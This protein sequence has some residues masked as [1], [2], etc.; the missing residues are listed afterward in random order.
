MARI[1]YGVQ[2]EGRGHSSR[3]KIII[4]HL[5]Q[6]G[7]QVK[8]FTSYK[9]YEYLCQFFDDVTN[10]LGLGFVFDGAQL[11]I[12]RTMQ[13]NIQDGASD[14][15]K[16]IMVLYKTFK[17]FRPD[18]AITDFEPFV[19]Y[20]RSL[21]NIPFI[22][23]NHQHIIS[24]YHLEYPY[25]WR[26]DYL[27]AR[28][29]V[30]NMYWFADHYYVTSFYFPRVRGQFRKRS[31]LVPPLLRTEVLA[32]E[33]TH[34]GHILIYATTAEARRALDLARQT[35]RRFVAYGFAEG[36]AVA[37]NIVLKKPGTEAFL[38]DLASA[39]A[40]ITNGGYT[41][42][43]EALYLGKPV[44]SL[45]INGQFE[46]MLNGYY[47]EKLGYGLYDLKPKMRRFEMFL[48][49]LEY[50]R[51]NM[52]R[53]KARHFGNRELFRKLDRRIEELC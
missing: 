39:E 43:S 31:S 17:E 6:E 15:G 13:R 12:S 18:L 50:F 37:D 21:A 29:V 46:Q 47:L 44:Y 27:R 26:P 53:D 48:E 4:E 35:K 1:I 42:M 51:E 34:G 3:S 23:I 8:I 49:G 24:H 11:D 16:T 25:R 41:L 20:A 2:G 19:P 52:R 33:N 14:A 28:A 45:P 9:G 32:Q 10:I 30:D 7:H 40:V 5:L 38:R 36:T 22:S